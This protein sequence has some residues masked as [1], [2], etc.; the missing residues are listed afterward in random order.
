MMRRIKHVFARLRREDGAGAVEMAFAMTGLVAIMFG[1]CEFT[2]AMYA[3]HFTSD[4]AREA[5]RYAMVRGSTSC[6]NTPNLTNCNATSAEIQ[7]WVQGLNYPG[8]VTGN[9]TATTTWYTASTTDPNPGTTTTWS[10]CSSGTCN[11]PGNLAK[12]K[13]SYPLT[14][15]IPFYTFSFT[16]SSTSQVVIAQ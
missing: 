4:A 12:V 10:L 14:F 13:V 9:V 15:S 16:L 1:I 3:G 7:T 5:S 2:L 8:I 6:T 11:K